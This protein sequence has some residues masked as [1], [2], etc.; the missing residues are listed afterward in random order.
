[1]QVQAMLSS[2]TNAPILELQ[3]SLK[4][5]K[6]GRLGRDE[7]LRCLDMWTLGHFH[8]TL[9]HVR[10]GR[11]ETG[12]CGAVN[13]STMVLTIRKK[14]EGARVHLGFLP[15]L[16]N[17]SLQEYYQLMPAPQVESL[18]NAAAYRF[19]GQISAGAR[20]DAIDSSSQTS[21]CLDVSKSLSMPAA[22]H[23]VRLQ[24]VS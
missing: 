9:E 17:P 23:Q 12:C 5:G 16:D 21:H 1:M 22:S 24:D 2:P 11:L 7:A 13:N 18:K 15:T 8:E 4:H 10:G 6:G 19:H 3:H 14:R 20:C